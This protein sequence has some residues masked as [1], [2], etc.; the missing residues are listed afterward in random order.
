MPKS[1]PFTFISEVYTPEI[2]MEPLK[3]TLLKRKIIWTKHPFLA[4]KCL[5]S[6][7]SSEIVTVYLAKLNW[8]ERWILK[9]HFL[10]GKKSHRM[11]NGIE[12]FLPQ[13][14]WRITLTCEDFHKQRF[15][16]GDSTLVNHKFL[17]N[18]VIPQRKIPPGRVILYHLSKCCTF[19]LKPP[20]VFSSRFYPKNSNP[21]KKKQRC[22]TEKIWR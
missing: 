22:L 8:P 5:F 6:G 2:S 7:V 12:A 11:F 16:F 4:W 14:W 9:P 18:W 20:T 10:G 17:K 15:H 21:K 1:E 19:W 3:I 13:N